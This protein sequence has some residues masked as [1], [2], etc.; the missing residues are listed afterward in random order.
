MSEESKTDVYDYAVAYY[1]KPDELWV[2]PNV[3]SIH[4]ARAS[5]AYC[6]TDP[7]HERSDEYFIVQRPV[8]KWER[9]ENE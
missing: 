1:W 6:Q 4:Y 5:L 2:L 8:S 7:K 3:G 9:V